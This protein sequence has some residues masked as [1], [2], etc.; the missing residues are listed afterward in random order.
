MHDFALLPDYYLVHITP[1]VKISFFNS[2]AIAAGWTS[3]GETMRYFPDQPSKFV[4]IPRNPEKKDQIVTVD[5]GVFHVSL[6][7]YY[8]YFF[9]RNSLQETQ[10]L[11]WPKI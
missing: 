3:P 6:I 10:T 9:I 5:T 7:N 1:F 8:T 4:L 11:E 2:F